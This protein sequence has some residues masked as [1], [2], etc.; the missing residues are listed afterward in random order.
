MALDLRTWIRRE[1]R[2]VLPAA[3][4][5]PAPA[6]NPTI[7][8]QVLLPDLPTSDPGVA[9]ALWSDGGIVKVSAG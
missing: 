2:A 1:L 3:A 9:G 7:T 4:W 5:N 6:H 8:G